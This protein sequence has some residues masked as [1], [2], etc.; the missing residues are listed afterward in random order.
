M[1]ARLP[2]LMVVRLRAFVLALVLCVGACLHVCNSIAR[3][4]MGRREEQRLLRSMFVESAAQWAQRETD[5]ATSSFLS[6]WNG[7]RAHVS[8]EAKEATNAT[9]MHARTDAVMI[10]GQTCIDASAAF[11]RR[12]V[13][14]SKNNNVRMDDCLLYTSDA[15]D[16]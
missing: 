4:K 3:K 7:S 12:A 14:S 8:K 13:L 2:E 5:P 6:F 10:P 16:E 11:Y 1:E 15:A 9:R